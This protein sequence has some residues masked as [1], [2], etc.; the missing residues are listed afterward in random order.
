MNDPIIDIKVQYSEAIKIIAEY[1]VKLN[2]LR[3]EENALTKEL[4]DSKASVEEITNLQEKYAAKLAATRVEMDY[5][6]KAIQ[7][8]NKEIQD[9][10][11]YEQAQEGSIAKLRA[12]LALNVDAYNKLSEAQ[13]QVV[14]AQFQQQ[15]DETSQK[16]AE[17]EKALSNHIRSV[18]DFESAIVSLKNESKEYTA[19]LQASPQIFEGINQGLQTV[20][21]AYGLYQSALELVGIENEELAETMRKLQIVTT[22]LAHVE[23]IRKTLS[24][25]TTMMTLAN[26][27][28]LK[29]ATALQNLFGLSV[30]AT[31][32]AFKVLRGAIIATGL[33]ALIVLVGALINNLDKLTSWF[34]SSAKAE[35]EAAKAAAAYEE[36]RKKT[37]VAITQ[38][39]NDEKNSVNERKNNLREEI[40]EL[41]K[42]GATSEQIAQA[43]MKAEQD[44]RDMAIKASQ[45][46][47]AQQD[48]E[49]KAL[50]ESLAAEE[51]TLATYGEKSKKYQEQRKAVDE[52]KASL[53][54]LN[55]AR[56]EETQVQADLIIQGKEAVQQSQDQAKQRAQQAAQA[57]KERADKEREAIRQAEDAALALV[58]EGVEKQRQAINQSYDRQIEDLKRKLL[59]EKNLTGPAKEALNQTIIA[60]D[61]KRQ[62]EL[63]KISEEEIKKRIENE[64]KLIE[65]QLQSVKQGTE[66][67]YQLRLQ[68]LV[69]QE[70]AELNNAELTGEMRA[71]IRAKY[72]KQFDDLQD[73]KIKKRLDDEKAAIDL[74]W[75][76]RFDSVMKG[77]IKESNL[78][79]QQAQEE[80]DALLNM[81]KATKDLLFENETAYT[82]ALLDLDD[83][84]KQAKLDNQQMIRESVEIQLQA[85]QA[86]GDGFS[87][88]LEAFAGDNEAL[89]AFAKTIALFNIGLST[90][91]ALAKGVAA[92]QSV[93]FPGN[94]LAIATTIGTILANIA[95]AK[96]MLSKESQPKAPKFS[97]GGVVSGS[98][99]GS[100]DTIV[101]KLS[102]GES[103]L[104]A[105]TTAM[106]APVLSALNQIGGGIPINIVQTS[107]Q[108]MGEEMLARAFAKGIAS[109]PSPVVSVQ[110]INTM[111][112]RV[113]TLES[114]SLGG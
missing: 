49:K 93:P 14:G 108:A 69:K 95:K 43:K 18:G 25:E 97:T 109:L 62:Q 10:I 45:D 59:E 54:A 36:Q 66:Q 46:R 12:E 27:V 22:A 104:T 44:I 28:A 57:A 85:A 11:Q 99:S 53:D 35:K 79:L 101:A 5:S 102:S 7:T 64:T 110:D 103:I 75:R 6:Q 78:K 113:R 29:A 19:Q 16:L 42:S 65:L 26:N 70:E 9:N 39:N 81:D 37:A 17:E 80:Y 96:Q 114:L 52:L 68:Q 38:I 40:L 4:K 41:K 47:M 48:A 63:D 73:E 33:G 74:E 1:T 2:Q 91:E 112:E 92:A 24:K 89:A 34:S 107:N 15:I 8:L 71:A 23:T 100:S 77:S 50:L 94:L 72:E 31:S 88:V 105:P 84:L 51:K 60:L 61:R 3:E 32:V 13:K 30:T 67:E 83:K 106:F 82:N 55:Q 58:E 86:I 76:Q 87:Q 111:Q 20:I 98:G 56:A 21:G 90:A